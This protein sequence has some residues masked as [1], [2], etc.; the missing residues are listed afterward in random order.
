MVAETMDEYVLDSTEA[1]YENP[2]EQAPIGL[3]TSCG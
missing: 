1:A 2:G 3:M